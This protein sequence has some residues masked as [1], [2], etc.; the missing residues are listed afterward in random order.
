MC[1]G[2]NKS[3]LLNK[4]ASV[5]PIN[6]QGNFTIQQSVFDNIPANFSVADYNLQKEIICNIKYVCDTIKLHTPSV[7]CDISQPVTITA[8]KNPL[9][10]GKVNFYFDTASVQSYSQPN[11][12]T[13]LLQFT[14]NYRGKI[15]AQPASC[16]KLKDSVEITVNK[17]LPK[18]NLGSDSIYCPGKKYFFNA[19]NLGFK[20]YRWQDGT[21]DSIFIAESPGVYS[22]TATDYCNRIYSDTIVI[23][24]STSA[25]NLGADKSICKGEEIQLSV[26]S[27]Y[28]NY[29]WQPASDITTINQS[30]VLAT[31]QNSK[32][33]SVNADIFPGCNLSD[34][35]YVT[36]NDCEEYIFFPSSFTPNNDGLNDLFKPLLSCAIASYELSIYNRWGQLVFKTTD[37]LKGWNGSFNNKKQATEAFVWICRY[38]FVG[39]TEKLIKGNLILIN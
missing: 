6:W 16:D 25:L 29:S 9:C 35:L 38:R 1:F 34:S 13:L 2:E 28:T 31:P 23:K 27:G 15:F 11:D 32:W 26:Q 24:P 21:S 30:T 5:S 14:E 19:Y 20:S 3:F 18:I 39:K 22:V 8:Y 10:N 36:V 12:T 4:P 7:V 37:K 17:A 33:Y